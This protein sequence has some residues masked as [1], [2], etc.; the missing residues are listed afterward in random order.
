M[1]E[2]EFA[3]SIDFGAGEGDF[4]FV[5]CVKEPNSSLF[6]LLKLNDQTDGL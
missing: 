2:N 4:I 6:S 3:N 1:G 5:L